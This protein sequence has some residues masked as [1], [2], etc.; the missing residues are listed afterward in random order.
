MTLHAVIW[1]AILAGGLV[2]T[3]WFLIRFRPAW[4]I[5][6]PSLIVNGLVG[7]IWLIYLRS[8]LLLALGGGRPR[9]TGPVDTAIV[10]VLGLAAD[11]LLVL[12][13]ATFLD[14]RRE[15]HDGG[16]PLE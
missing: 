5:R 15:R 13:L 16:N 10:I 8:A 6:R 3:T 14:Y 12:M 11:L 1:W 4:P 9:Y 2:P 7:V